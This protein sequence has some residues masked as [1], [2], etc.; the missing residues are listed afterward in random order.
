MPLM[1]AAVRFYLSKNASGKGVMLEPSQ[2]DLVPW[3]A[4]PYDGVSTGKH[5]HGYIG[6]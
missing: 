2:C 5:V 3:M 6:G 1:F 4:C